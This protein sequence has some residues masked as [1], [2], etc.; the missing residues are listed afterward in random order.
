MTKSET[1]YIIKVSL[2]LQS[3]L[4]VENAS[5]TCQ[6]GLGG[7]CGHLIGL[8]YQVVHCKGQ[9]HKVIPVD[10]AKISLLQKIS[11]GSE[12]Y[13]SGERKGLKSNCTTL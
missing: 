13:F 9:G 8:L 2:V 7:V 3:E 10:I 6:K 4:T 1:P 12:S 11:G 5:C